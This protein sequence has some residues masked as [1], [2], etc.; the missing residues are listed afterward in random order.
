[1][2]MLTMLFVSQVFANVSYKALTLVFLERIEDLVSQL[3]EVVFKIQG[4]VF[5]IVFSD[6]R[7]AVSSDPPR[8]LRLNPSDLSEVAPFF[9]YLRK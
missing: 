3:L 8:C 9:E 2:Q 6:C 7:Q 1:M 5:V 4:L